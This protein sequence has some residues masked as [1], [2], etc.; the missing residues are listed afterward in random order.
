MKMY[1]VTAP[2]Y[3]GM[4]VY[5]NK[6]E[7]QPTFNRVTNAHVTESRLSLDVHTGTH[8]DA[9]LHMINDADTIE[10]IPLEKIVGS[11]KVFDLT[12]VED[13]ITKDDLQGLTI[14]KNDFVLFKTSNSFDEEFNFDFIYIKEDAATYLADL[15]IR[16]VGID[17]LGV[18]RSQPGHPT[19]K[20]LFSKDIIVIEGLRLKEVPAGEYFMV[21][22]PLKLIG[23]D[24]APARVLLF[25]GL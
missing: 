7:K 14:E 8:M 17:A 16:G 4:P 23:T 25:E 1:D 19:H 22:A 6:P 11:C 15:S 2:I 20:A 24:A 5:K 3:E 9:P 10:T 21:A 13:G 18:E 12:K